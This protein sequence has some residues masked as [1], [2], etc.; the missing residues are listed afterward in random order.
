[1]LISP[2]NFGWAKDFLTF[3][4]TA[5]MDEN[6][7][8]T[9]EGKSVQEQAPQSQGAESHR[10]LVLP[11]S[12]DGTKKK[13]NL[14]RPTPVVESEFCSMNAEDLLY[15]NLS[16]GGGKM[17]PVA[18]KRNKNASIKDG[19]SG[20]GSSKTGGKNGQGSS[21]AGGSVPKKP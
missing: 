7:E 19:K 18:R 9:V 21:K 12:S 5:F 6:I 17:E 10:A 15:E 14:K 16:Q 1:M 8:G 3:G 4:A 20:Q 11:S 2:E 13:K